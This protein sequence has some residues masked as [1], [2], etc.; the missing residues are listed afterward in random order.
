MALKIKPYN[1]EVRGINM[2]VFT[3][4]DGYLHATFT[5]KKDK[6]LI[7]KGKV[8]WK[9]DAEALNEKFEEIITPKAGRLFDTVNAGSHP[10]YA[11]VP[12][13]NKL[14]ALLHSEE[15]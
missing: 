7:C 14:I 3:T 12:I 6:A 1:K 15:K 10:S 4:E 13:I 5:R 2:N 11:M 9:L 8:Q